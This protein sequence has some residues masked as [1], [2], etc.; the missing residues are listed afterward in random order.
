MYKIY[1]FTDVILLQYE[2]K[3]SHPVSICLACLLLNIVFY[4]NCKKTDLVYN[5]LLNWYIFALGEY[6]KL[7]KIAVKNTKHLLFLCLC[8]I[9]VF[10]FM[11]AD[12]GVCFFLIARYIN[13]V[14]A[15]TLVCDCMLVLSVLWDH[16][17][18]LPS[19]SPWVPLGRC[20]SLERCCRSAA[21]DKVV[22]QRREG[23]LHPPLIRPLSLSSPP[24]YLLSISL[25]LPLLTTSQTC[26]SFRIPHSI[27][28]SHT[29][30]FLTASSCCSF[31]LPCL[32]TFHF[33]FP[34]HLPFQIH[35]PILLRFRY[36]R[37]WMTISLSN[38]CLLIWCGISRRWNHVEGYVSVTSILYVAL[39][40]AL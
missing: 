8:N 9:H 38:C 16:R 14:C 19:A 10:Q 12:S 6:K 1:W 27:I 4:Y 30:V 37:W 31:L 20:S 17:V 25:S 28:V 7:S 3:F 15:C 40:I 11:W 39:C 35:P 5:L 29:A 13:T 22:A 33:Y 23:R 18:F 34:F 2:N 32:L 21:G 36:L 24:L 26:V